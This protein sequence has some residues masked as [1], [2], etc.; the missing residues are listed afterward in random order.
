[1]LRIGSV[2]TTKPGRT[3]RTRIVNESPPQIVGFVS[4]VNT[5]ELAI[6]VLPDVS[7]VM[8]NGADSGS[9]HVMIWVRPLNDDNV[10]GMMKIQRMTVSMNRARN[11][12]GIGR[13][14]RTSGAGVG[15]AVTT[16][17]LGRRGCS[18]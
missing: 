1:M 5:D 16:S 18:R 6:T 10:I 2:T 14:S 15:M 12:V 11:D 4:R 3:L 17:I 9:V 7:V 8:L 13:L